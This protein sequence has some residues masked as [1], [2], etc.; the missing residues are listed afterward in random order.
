MLSAMAATSRLMITEAERRFAVR[1]RV[2]VPPAGFGER[3][4]RIAIKK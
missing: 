2:A 1:V 4:N 3:L